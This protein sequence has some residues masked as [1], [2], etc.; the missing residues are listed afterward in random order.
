MPKKSGSIDTKSGSRSYNRFDIQ[1]SQTLHMAIELYPN[2]NYLLVLDHYDDIAVFDDDISPKYA[3]FYQMKTSED[4]ISVETAISE[5]WFEKLYEHLN[6]PDW[7]VEELGLITNT[8]LKITV[9]CIGNDGKKHKETQKYS[10]DKVSFSEFNKD[11]I[12][13]IKSGIA[14]QN[15]ITPDEVDLSKFVHMRTT[16][17][18][19]RHREIVEQEMSSFL[20]NEYPKITV[21]TVKTIYVTLMDLLARRQ[22][23]EQLDKSS[24]FP[25]IREKKGLSKKDFTRIIDEAMYITIPDFQEIKGWAAFDNES[26][27]RAALEYTKILTDC[28]RKSESFSTLFFKIR[29]LCE[30]T[31]LHE[32]E[33]TLA[34]C[35][36]IYNLMPSKNPIYNQM[37]ISIIVII[38]LVNEWRHT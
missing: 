15:G 22:A 21:E 28:N 35:Q 8:P 37:Y 1:I 23:Y 29:K 20:Q 14:K 33:E 30:D 27:L 38:T 26:E 18:I 25:T 17:S 7:I 36:R 9:K 24:T 5:K 16:L 6:N 34:Y 13:K 2:L 4:S 31:P 12:T 3:S 32:N 10:S 11:T 19:E